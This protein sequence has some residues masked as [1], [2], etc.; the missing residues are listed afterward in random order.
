MGFIRN[1]KVWEHLSTTSDND[2]ISGLMQVT[3]TYS[4]K[5]VECVIVDC[6][7]M[8]TKSAVPDGDYI[9]WSSDRKFL[10]EVTDWSSYD[11][12]Q[13]FQNQHGEP[14]TPPADLK[15]QRVG[16]DPSED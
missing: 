4:Q 14:L 16:Y 15:W 13:S 8:G 7:S 1:L 10:E 3:R 9:L 2:V 12:R 6:F 5:E 11:E